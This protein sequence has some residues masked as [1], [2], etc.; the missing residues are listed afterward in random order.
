MTQTVKQIALDMKIKAQESQFGRPCPTC[1]LYPFYLDYG[2]ALCEGHVYSPNGRSELG[3]TGMC[4]WCWDQMEPEDEKAL[5]TGGTIDNSV[6][7]DLPLEGLVLQTV[8]NLNDYDVQS[9]RYDTEDKE[10]AQVITS[11]VAQPGPRKHKLVIDLD[12]PAQLIPSSTPGHFHL[13]VDHEMDEGVYMEL[14]AALGKAGLVEPGY[15][16]ASHERK[17]TAVRLPWVHKP[18]PAAEELVDQAIAEYMAEQP[19]S[20]GGDTPW[21]F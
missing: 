10:A 13:Y 5:R 6:P 18:S 12:L 14:L 16:R 4:E 17:L 2:T 21:S 19:V 15:V 11:L 9:G 3:I 8:T 7:H 20:A 1:K